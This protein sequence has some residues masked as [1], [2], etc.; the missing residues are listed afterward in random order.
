MPIRTW[1]LATWFCKISSPL[2]RRQPEPSAP[3]GTGQVSDQWGLPPG[4]PYKVPIIVPALR[5]WV[6]K[7]T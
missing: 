4:V 5:R 3:L 1:N 6:I 7:A 2:F